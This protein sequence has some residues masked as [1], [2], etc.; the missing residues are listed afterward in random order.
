MK[1]KLTLILFL[2]VLSIT[3]VAAIQEVWHSGNSETKS[4]SSEGINI[5][6][7]TSDNLKCLNPDGSQKWSKNYTINDN[8]QAIKIS[9]YALIGT[10]DDLRALNLNN[11]SQRWINYEPLGINQAIKY[12]FAKQEYILASNDNKAVIL[13]RETG[14]NKTQ[15]IDINTLCKPYLTQG[16]YLT[17]TTTGIQAYKS[18]LLPDLYIKNTKLESG[19]VTATIENKGLGTAKNV[20]VKFFYRK[21]DG[22]L[23]TLH[24]NLGDL[25]EG[26]SRDVP[27]YGN[28][29]AGYINIDPYYTI[30]E[31]NEDNN[32]QYFTY[33]QQNNTN[34][35]DNQTEN[36]TSPIEEFWLE[37]F[38]YK[39]NA[40]IQYSGT[41][42]L[43]DY[44]IAKVLVNFE[45]GKIK[46]NFDD[47]RF[48]S[49]NQ[50]LNYTL[51]SKIDGDKAYFDVKVPLIKGNSGTNLTMFSGNANAV[52]LSNPDNTYLLYDHFKGTELN[53][54]KW[55]ITSG[56]PTINNSILTL[57]GTGSK[58]LCSKNTFNAP[59][60]IEAKSRMEGIYSQI[61]IGPDKD[62]SSK[63]ISI[64][65]TMPSSSAVLYVANGSGY[66]MIGYNSL[67]GTESIRG[68]GYYNHIIKGYEN[69][70]LING[71]I[72]GFDPNGPYYIEITG[73]YSTQY[74]DYILA[75]NY[76]YPE[77]TLGN[78][79]TWISKT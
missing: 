24:R 61:G 18:I 54:S 30:K 2:I 29:T 31:L 75:R 57:A 39:S 25:Q 15:I 71:Q 43:I 78:W 26:Q 69:G 77:P 44:T 17:G 35:G 79:G 40:N 70:E 36:T 51:K 34:P 4:L 28:M 3:T 56:T 7:A 55:E 9:K 16:H 60:Y 68:I 74:V 37:G 13:D 32:Q 63:L 58:G 47:V 73:T 10:D 6:A 59:I 50:I 27:L 53:S 62:L 66:N 21:S 48:V 23:K 33:N 52:S 41:T 46:T 76:I 72:E 38:N 67:G 8:G 22:S 49:G 45:T 64:Y 11:G 12:I 5:Y 20:V 14:E 42:D 65:G 19:K 1:I